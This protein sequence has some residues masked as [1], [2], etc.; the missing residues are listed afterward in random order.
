M[1]M[2]C[3]ISIRGALEIWFAESADRTDECINP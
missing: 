1:G 3:P 2:V